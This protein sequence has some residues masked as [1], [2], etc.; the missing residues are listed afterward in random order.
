MYNYRTVRKRGANVVSY[1]EDESDDEDDLMSDDEGREKENGL[2][3]EP[4]EQFETIERVMDHRMGKKG[5]N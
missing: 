3:A 2:P 4:E 5:G 1:K